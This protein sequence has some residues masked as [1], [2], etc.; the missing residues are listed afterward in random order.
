MKINKKLI[1]E[2]IEMVQDAILQ[3]MP[4]QAITKPQNKIK[5]PVNLVKQCWKNAEI[6][7]KALEKAGDRLLKAMRATDD[8][9]SEAANAIVDEGEP[10]D[11]VGEA[12]W[13]VHLAEIIETMRENKENDGEEDDY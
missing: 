8:E 3:E 4:K 12:G 11:Q 13:G 9:I 5:V 7:K 10:D 6:A 2:E 1:A